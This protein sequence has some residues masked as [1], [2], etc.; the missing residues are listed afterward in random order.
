VAADLC[1][2]R[3]GHRSAP[4][5]SL[6]YVIKIY[7]RLHSWT[8]WRREKSHDTA[9]NPT[10]ILRFS[11]LSH[12]TV[13]ANWTV[14]LTVGL[15]SKQWQLAY[16]GVQ[17]TAKWILKI[18]VRKLVPCMW[19]GKIKSYERIRTVILNEASM[20][21]NLWNIILGDV[22]L[23]LHHSIDFSKYQLSAQLF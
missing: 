13:L 11:S 10:T 19:W 18:I 8:K 12:F 14:I 9:E 3:R 2:S 21:L 22:F 1:L 5:S 23:T 15:Q 4:R 7:G 20:L 6:G 17:L 16:R